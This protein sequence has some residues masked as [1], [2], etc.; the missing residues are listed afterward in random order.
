MKEQITHCLHRSCE[1]YDRAKRRRYRPALYRNARGEWRCPQC[2]RHY[3]REDQ[4]C[5]G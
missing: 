3:N 5:L 2:D 1:R 4:R